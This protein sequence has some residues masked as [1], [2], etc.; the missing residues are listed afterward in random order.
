MGEVWLAEQKQPVHRRVALK[1]IKAGMDTREVV[2]RF[3][4]ERQALALMDHLPLPRSSTPAP[5]R[6]AGRTSSWNMS[7]GCPS[8]T[9]ATAIA[10]PCGSAWN[11]SSRGTT[12]G[13]T[14]SSPIIR[15]LRQNSL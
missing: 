14:G 7:L 3:E 13:R 1:L 9:I 10:S 8:A 12:R 15:Q 11:S 6:K 2:A 5:R 4:S